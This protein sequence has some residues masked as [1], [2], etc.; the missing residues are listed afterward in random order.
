LGRVI[1]KRVN[2][3]GKRFSWVPPRVAD[4]HSYQ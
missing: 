4:L 2:Y 1:A 3:G